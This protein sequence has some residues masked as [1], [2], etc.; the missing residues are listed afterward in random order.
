MNAIVKK[1]DGKEK[2]II[3]AMF[4]LAVFLL[5]L[6]A[7]FLNSAVLNVVERSKA[8]RE[9]VA[10]RSKVAELEVKYISLKDRITLNFAYEAG[11][12]DILK[13]HFV[14]RKSFGKVLSL[15]NEL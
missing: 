6:Y 13:T 10:L 14:A 15:N 9:A 1:I 3:N 12:E 2:F 8:E 11:F 7:Y 5:L 4:S